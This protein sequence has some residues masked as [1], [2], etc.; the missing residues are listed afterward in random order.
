MISDTLQV[1]VATLE[2]ETGWAVKPVGACREDVCV[3][4][5]A[6]TLTGDRVDLA[7]FADRLGMPVAHDAEH[8]IW[9]LGPQ[10]GGKAMTTVQAPDLVLPTLDGEPF[11]LSSLRGRKVLIV[12][13]ASW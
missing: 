5:P 3:P 13:W 11:A 9:S 2:R 4:L 10:A 1:D 12:S 7:A 6:G 8:G